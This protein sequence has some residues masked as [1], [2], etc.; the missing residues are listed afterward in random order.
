MSNI[1]NSGYWLPVLVEASMSCTEGC[2]CSRCKEISMSD[3]NFIATLF[4]KLGVKSEDAKKAVEILSDVEIAKNPPHAQALASGQYVESRWQ[5]G[6][7]HKVPPANVL[8]V[9]PTQESSGAGAEKMVSEYSN[10]AP[11]MGVQLEAERLAAE[12]GSMRGHMK[13]MTD[14]HNG[15]V[16]EVSKTTH[17]V[18][19]LTTVM[20]AFLAKA[21]DDEKKKEKDKDEE[22]HGDKA[23][24]LFAD[25]KKLL[26]KSKKIRVEAKA[27]TEPVQQ[28]SLKKAAK[29]YRL[30]AARSIQK[31]QTEALAG[32]GVSIDYTFE[33]RK[34]IT[35][36]IEKNPAIKND[37]KLIHEHED[38]DEKKK[39]KKAYKKAKTASTSE[40]TAAKAVVGHSDAKG[41]QKDGQDGESKNQDDSSV[42]AVQEGLEKIDNALN[43][44]GM[45]KTNVQGLIDAVSGRTA[46]APLEPVVSLIKSTGQTKLEAISQKI[47]KA[48]EEGMDIPLI[49]KARALLVRLD[50]VNQGAVHK[51]VF[52][53][54]L[55]NAPAR[56]K[57]FF[58]A[59]A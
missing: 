24:S 15:L 35:S 47:D 52:E 28:K 31:A 19:N 20:S 48:D 6:Q 50:G 5:E 36:F 12:L 33:T 18:G 1:G 4:N 29:A 49:M 30:A 46:T 58:E 23:C 41:N 57:E 14:A 34:A 27:A 13:S 38:G 55:N 26:R 3:S 11:Q 44:L 40:D 7:M 37:L 53:S 25:A 10:P 56:V 2:G 9:G 43:G 8:K 22:M 42:K 45:L 51:G 54:E 21:E 16:D 32:R 17:Q 39:A 59:A